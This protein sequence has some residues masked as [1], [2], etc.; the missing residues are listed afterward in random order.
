M[1]SHSRRQRSTSNT[2]AFLRGCTDAIQLTRAPRTTSAQLEGNYESLEWQ[3]GLRRSEFG[4]KSRSVSFAQYNASG[5]TSVHRRRRSSMV[6]LVTDAAGFTSSHHTRSRRGSALT[7]MEGEESGQL[8]RSRRGSRVTGSTSSKDRRA[9]QVLLGN[10]LNM[11]FRSDSRSDSRRNSRTASTS[12]SGH[13]DSAA[14]ALNMEE[15]LAHLT[16]VQGSGLSKF[17]ED[18]VAGASLLVGGVD[19]AADGITANHGMRVFVRSDLSDS[20]AACV[21]RLVRF[22][23][24]GRSALLSEVVDGQRSRSKTKL[25]SHHFVGDIGDAVLTGSL[26]ERRSAGSPAVEPE[27]VA[28]EGTAE[29]VDDVMYHV[30]D[31]SVRE[32]HCFPG[33]VVKKQYIGTSGPRHRLAMASKYAAKAA[34]A[35]IT[36]QLPEE[37]LA[38]PENKG[39]ADSTAALTPRGHMESELKDVVYNETVSPHSLLEY[40]EGEDYFGG[41]K[42]LVDSHDFMTHDSGRLAS[43]RHR[44]LAVARSQRPS[45]YDQ[46]GALSKLDQNQLLQHEEFL[47]KDEG[48]QGH[49]LSNE[50]AEDWWYASEEQQALNQDGKVE[51]DVGVT[52]IVEATAGAMTI[53]VQQNQPLDDERM[54]KEK[55][56]HK[57]ALTGPI[58]SA[59]SRI[60]FEACT[61]HQEDYTGGFMTKDEVATH[62]AMNGGFQGSHTSPGGVEGAVKQQYEDANYG[63]LRVRVRRASAGKLLRPPVSAEVA[64]QWERMNWTRWS[65]SWEQTTHVRSHYQLCHAGQAKTAGSA[66]RPTPAHHMASHINPKPGCSTYSTPSSVYQNE[67]EFHGMPPSRSQQGGSVQTMG[68]L[69]TEPSSAHHT[70][71]H[72]SSTS[73][74]GNYQPIHQHGISSRSSSWVHTPAPSILVLKPRTSQSARLMSVGR[75]T[76]AAA[77][78]HHRRADNGSIR[79]SVD[80]NAINAR[81]QCPMTTQSGSRSVPQCPASP[82]TAIGTNKGASLHSNGLLDSLAA[83]SVSL[84]GHRVERRGDGRIQPC[85][86]AEGDGRIQSCYSA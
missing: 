38:V 18:V 70:S 21:N 77:T 36:P 34:A 45:S 2:E 47:I 41:L 78:I 7:V 32:A 72:L 22:T 35:A 23:D 80:H 85:Y 82:A 84:M 43:L 1:A 29:L 14:L 15:V 81:Q 39:D 49:G 13:A 67:A 64:R 24:H 52:D 10:Y 9:S 17:P 20:G 73:T 53:M 66:L 76:T 61:V 48:Q 57:S 4:S 26:R 58:D 51:S 56:K 54:S 50:T 44:S 69:V 71:H 40:D 68:G 16:E 27:A 42:Q 83:G 37:P 65:Q 25:G 46:I 33:R 12:V 5:S 6:A 63:Y 8:T 19:N 28:G 74:L 79:P 30:R 60:P 75:P 86:S 31:S 62:S 11:S 3:A 59:G 55:L